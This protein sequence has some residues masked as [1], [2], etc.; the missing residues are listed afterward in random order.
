[1][2]QTEMALI[3]RTVENRVIQQRATDGYINAT[4]MCTVANKRFQN[5]RQLVST[6]EFLNALESRTGIPVLEL[7]RSI[8]GG[9]P[10]LRGVWVHPQVAINLAQWVSPSFAVR[11]TE[12]VFEW[13]SGKV[14]QRVRLPDHVRRYLI[15]Q[16]KIPGTHFSMLNQMIFRLLAPLEEYG[17]ILPAHLMPDISLGKMFSGWLRDK[18][19]DPNS[20]PT[21]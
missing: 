3:D 9:D 15:N 7:I 20:F 6:Q 18:G 4:A 16:S 11:V 1:M 17:Y 19:D 8:R 10:E 21:L 12:W 5:Y 13:L 14:E 2:S